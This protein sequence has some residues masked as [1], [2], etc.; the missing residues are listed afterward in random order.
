MGCCCSVP[1]GYEK[2]SQD[3]S[4]INSRSS[5]IHAFVIC[6]SDPDSDSQ[7]QIDSAST[8]H[9]LLACGLQAGQISFFGQE[10]SILSSSNN[11]EESQF[12]HFSDGSPNVFL[13]E[14]TRFPLSLEAISSSLKRLRNT[15]SLLVFF[16]GHGYQDGILFFKE[17]IQSQDFFGPFIQAR[18]KGV[19]KSAVFFFGS[20][21]SKNIV[22]QLSDKISFIFIT[23]S[24]DQNMSLMVPCTLR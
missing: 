23:S 19:F 22:T 24:N 6:G 5:S 4:M 15:D 3:A 9:F 17:N 1:L 13:N 16:W 12:S 2:L 8:I 20:C 18:N 10:F 7:D 14:Y 21:F 11:K